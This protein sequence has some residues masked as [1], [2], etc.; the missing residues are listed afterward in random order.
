MKQTT[1]DRIPIQDKGLMTVF[2]L[3]ISPINELFV[4]AKRSVGGL[5]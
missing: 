3:M 5:N 2:W 4:G 1:I